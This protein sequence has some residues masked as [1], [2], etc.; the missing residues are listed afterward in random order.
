MR[1]F[2]S[3]VMDGATLKLASTSPAALT[4]GCFDRSTFAC[5]SARSLTLPS[6]KFT[7]SGW[8]K[9]NCPQSADSCKASTRSQS[10]SPEN[11]SA[12]TKSTDACSLAKAV[13]ESASSPT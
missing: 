1:T 9:R 11:S 12:P 2:G 8:R 5:S 3:A 7:S 10:K 13:A 4:N 6:F